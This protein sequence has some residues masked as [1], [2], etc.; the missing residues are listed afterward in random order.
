MRWAVKNY[1]LGRGNNIPNISLEDVF[2]ILK[3]HF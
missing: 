1:E 3:K 2:K